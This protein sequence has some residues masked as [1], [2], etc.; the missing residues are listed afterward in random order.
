MSLDVVNGSNDLGLCHQTDEQSHA[1]KMARVTTAQELEQY[2]SSNVTEVMPIFDDNIDDNDHKFVK[3]TLNEECKVCNQVMNEDSKLCEVCL[4][5]CHKE[6]KKDAFSCPPKVND[7]KPSYDQILLAKVYNT[8]FKRDKLHGAKSSNSTIKERGHHSSPSTLRNF[9]QAGSFR[10]NPRGYSQDAFD[11][12]STD[13]IDDSL[14]SSDKKR[15]LK[16]RQNEQC[17]VS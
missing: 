1:N 13:T 14:K 9:P 4:L 12:P 11:M 8:K 16:K 15:L 10:K 5:V 2:Y 3:N 6:C 7:Q 17:I